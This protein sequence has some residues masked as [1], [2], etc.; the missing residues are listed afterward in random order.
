VGRAAPC[1]RGEQTA[2]AIVKRD[3]QELNSDDGRDAFAICT[4]TPGLRNNPTVTRPKAAT[5]FDNEKSPALARV[6]QPKRREPWVRPASMIDSGQ[7]GHK[8]AFVVQTNWIMSGACVLSP[9]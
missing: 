2:A 4:K 6:L 9:N 5:P 1:T 3:S 7:R 8:G